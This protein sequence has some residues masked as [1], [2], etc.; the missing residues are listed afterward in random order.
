MKIKVGNA[1]VSWGVMEVAG[2]GEQ[3]AY[4]KVPDEIR[5]AGHAG[6]KLWPYGYFPT[7]PNQLMP[8]LSAREL[9]FSRREL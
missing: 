8:E 3:I 4:R 1:P 9:L 6:T 5:E 7:E 2:W